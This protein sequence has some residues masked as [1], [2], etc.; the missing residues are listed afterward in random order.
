MKAYI[1][2]R[3][4]EDVENLK[5]P[6][7]RELLDKLSDYPAVKGARKEKYFEVTLSENGY[8]KLPFLSGFL[9]RNTARSICKKLLANPVYEE[10]SF[11]LEGEKKWRK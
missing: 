11:R 4:R 8:R 7:E 3:F 1:L 9:A 6:E 10:Y 2:V 5:N